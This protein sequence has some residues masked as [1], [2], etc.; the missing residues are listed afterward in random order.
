MR[1]SISS[2][3]AAGGALLALA[4]CV[5]LPPAGGGTST[6]AVEPA[7]VIPRW[8]LLADDIARRLA[9]KTR[10]WPADAPAIHVVPSGA[11]AFHLG[12]RSL[13]VTRLR[14]RGVAVAVEPTGVELRVETQLLQSPG[15]R[16]AQLLVSTSLENDGRYLARTSDLFAVPAENVSLYLAPEPV[17]ATVLPLVER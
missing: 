7:P 17:S 16:R 3:L 6:E 4:G 10:A 8:D 9:N 5:A 11:S 14:E 1:T 13:L 2:T 12:L 15:S